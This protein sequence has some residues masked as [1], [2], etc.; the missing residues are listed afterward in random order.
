MFPA[1]TAEADEMGFHT[2]RD[3]I[4]NQLTYDC[5]TKDTEDQA[6]DCMKETAAARSIVQPLTEDLVRN[7]F[8][9][10]KAIVIEDETNA[11]DNV[12][13]ILTCES[14]N[15]DY[16]FGA[17]ILNPLVE[18]LSKPNDPAREQKVEI[19]IDLIA[20]SFKAPKSHFLVDMSKDLLSHKNQE[21]K[22]DECLRA[23]FDTHISHEA[24]A[25]V[26]LLLKVKYDYSVVTL[27]S[28]HNWSYHPLF[29]ISAKTALKKNFEEVHAQV[30]DG[31]DQL[32]QG[33]DMTFM[34]VMQ[35]IGQDDFLHSNKNQPA[36]PKQH[37]SAMSCKYKEILQ[38][39][40]YTIRPLTSKMTETSKVRDMQ[41]SLKAV[42]ATLGRKGSSSYINSPPV[43]LNCSFRKDEDDSLCQNVTTTFTATGL[44]YSFNSE[45]FFSLYKRSPHMETFCQEILGR[46]G[47]KACQVEDAKEKR[48][49]FLIM[50]NGPKF[51]LRLVL[52]T[53]QKDRFEW[54]LR[55]LSIHSPHSIPD[56]EEN[57]FEPNSGT[58]TTVIVTPHVTTADKKLLAMSRAI[59]K[60]HYQ[61][62]DGN[63]LKVFK[64]YT[65]DNCA[66]ECHLE[67]SIKIC[68]CV[69]WKYPKLHGNDTTCSHM[70]ETG[71]FED[72]FRKVK[73]NE[74]CPHCIYECN[75][76]D[77]AYTIHT[78]PLEN[79]CDTEKIKEAVNIEVNANIYN[80]LPNDYSLKEMGLLQQMFKPCFFY[81]HKNTAVVDV[82]IGPATAVRITSRPRVTFEDQLGSIGNIFSI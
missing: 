25:M 5:K 8:K 22:R 11:S 45:S 1:L 16:D 33:K 44:G 30:S 15:G 52:N 79:Q 6:K 74:K 69:P 40:K 54:S 24:K 68:G 72:T 63:P 31:M 18:V 59:R 9:K 73:N 21:I 20:K 28:W 38:V 23:Y 26:L 32:M 51:A 70:E 36:T 82:Y 43:M 78:K 37:T 35:F 61:E 76:V 3:T 39:A 53:P 77:Y 67:K 60:C 65:R 14:Y 66:F 4:L 81:S 10:Y 49:P 7:M 80:Y 57:F 41:Q 42:N 75:R 58:H 71:C 46:T 17:K 29:N 27:G 13:R 19:Y 62:A 56:F 34:D 12:I 47:Q 55:K 64:N 2:Q 48:K 50:K